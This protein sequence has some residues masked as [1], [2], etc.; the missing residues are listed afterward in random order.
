[1]IYIGKHPP[2]NK[3][4]RYTEV[5]TPPCSKPAPIRFLIT[6]RM[7]KSGGPLWS[8]PARLR[9]S[10]K[11]AWSANAMSLASHVSG[12]QTDKPPFMTSSASCRVPILRLTASPVMRRHLC[13]GWVC[14]R[15]GP[16]HRRRVRESVTPIA[17]QVDME[18][19]SVHSQNAICG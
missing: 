3:K 12:H 4:A 17:L 19:L 5:P 14:L 2:N 7:A 9:F 13:L 6:T 10:T 16:Q 18:N 11:A 1:V 8:D 15:G